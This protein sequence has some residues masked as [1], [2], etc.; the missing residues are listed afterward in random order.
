M[1]S[2][3]EIGE[4][5][6]GDIL[7]AL[8]VGVYVTDTERRIVFWNKHAEGITGYKAEEV[9]GHRCSAN[10]LRHRDKEG[11]PLCSTDL[12]PLHRA[13]ITGTRSEAP[14][15]V[16]AVSKTGKDLAL[17]VSTAPVYGDDGRVIGGVEVFRDEG[18]DIR[19]MELA[20]VVQRQM[21]TEGLPQDERL[22][23][24]VQYAPKELVSGDFY[25]VRRLSEDLFAVFVADAAGH[26]VSAALS[27]GLIYSLVMECKDLLPDPAGLM[28]A[29]NERACA[30]ATGLGF[31]TAV[32]AVLDARAKS[33]T[34]C[35]AG[36][37]PLLCQKGASGEVEAL[38]QSQL[39]VGVDGR[40]VYASH[41]M[42]LESGD[43]LLA[44]SDGVTDMPTGGSGRLGIDGLRSLLADC[45]PSDDPKL[46][47]LF[48]SVL[49]RCA[50]VEPDDDITLVSCAFR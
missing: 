48:E 14:V 50:A 24:A 49:A 6:F 20:R 42:D 36:H 10:I 23:F 31:F 13:I 33:V 34:F 9:V 22:S 45:R 35:S 30:R 11:R 4:R 39:P 19:Q 3:V 29:V 26:G 18:A 41:K 12:C 5:N 28:A 27:V 21:L 32:S 2:V 43:R 40:A 16:Y 17:S 8:N 47:R 46:R 1:Q 44:Y 25:H 7:N 15:L 37:P 38:A